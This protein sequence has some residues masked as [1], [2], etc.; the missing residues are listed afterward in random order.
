MS[1]ERREHRRARADAD[2]R[3]AARAA[4]ATRRGAR[5]ARA[6]SAARRRRRRSAPRKRRSACGVSA[7]SGTSTIALRP[8]VE[9][10]LRRRAGRPR[11]CP[12]RSR[13]GAGTARRRRA[14]RLAERR[15]DGAERLLLVGASAPA[16]PPAPTPIACRAGRRAGAP[17]RAIDTSPRPSRRR[18]A[19]GPERR[20]RRRARRAQRAQ[21]RALALGQRASPALSAA[22]PASVSSATSTRFARTPSAAP[23]GEHEASAR[24]GVEQYSSRHPRA[25]ARPDRRATR[26]QHRLGLGEP[27]GR[28][29]GLVR[30][31]DD[32]PERRRRPNGTRSSEPTPTA[33]LVRRAAGSR[34]ARERPACGSA[35]RRGRSRWASGTRRSRVESAS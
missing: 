7:I 28:Q 23:G 12:S 26:R 4:A 10:R 18:S 6:P 34:T 8:G 3:L 35:A 22:R 9:R 31:A 33:G 29:L 25:R 21:Q 13:R 20:R 19:G 5:R 11:S 32:D 15:D 27:L 14:A 16:R 2:P 24:A 1:L 17:R 30:R